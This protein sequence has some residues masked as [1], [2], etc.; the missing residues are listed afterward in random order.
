MLRSHLPKGP[1]LLIA[2][3]LVLAGCSSIGDDTPAPGAER[4]P[5]GPAGR[6]AACRALRGARR[7]RPDTRPYARRPFGLQRDLREA[8]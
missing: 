4:R 5:A 2:A 7:A 1:A 3:A 8:L 6:H